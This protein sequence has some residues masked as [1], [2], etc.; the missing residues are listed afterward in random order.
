MTGEEEQ[1]D[2]NDG[3]NPLVSGMSINMLDKILEGKKFISKACASLIYSRYDGQ[4]FT[5]EIGN[6]YDTGKECLQT[7]LA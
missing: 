3:F 7:F 5:D 2:L 4:D 6:L 1:M